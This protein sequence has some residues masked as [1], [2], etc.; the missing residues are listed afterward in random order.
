[1]LQFRIHNW[2][3]K[4]LKKGFTLVEILTVVFLSVIIVAAGYSLY[5]MSYQSFKKNT[6]SA[7]LAQNARI[8]LERM[9]R[10]IR[11][12]TDIVTD[13][14]AV[15][16]EIEFQDGHTTTPIQYIDY[17]L[18]G[19]ELQFTPVHYAFPSDPNTWVK[20]DE[21]I[22]GSLPERITPPPEI[23]PEIKAQKITVL[24]FWGTKPTINI[25]LTV[26]DGKTS[27]QFETSSYGRN[28]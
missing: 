22:N 20:H 18:V 26:S 19:S 3:I 9:T 10:D 27:Y 2:K 7:E 24:E 21:L 11:Q 23:P 4:K 13:L 14:G 12:A 17:K 1:M 5:S 28:L 8:A 6:A 16:A 25:S 15:S